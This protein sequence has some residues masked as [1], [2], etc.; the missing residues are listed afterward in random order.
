MN[1]ELKY[2]KIDA[3]ENPV[4]GTASSLIDD[5]FCFMMR[6]YKKCETCRYEWY[7]EEPANE[8]QVQL[9]NPR[10]PNVWTMERCLKETFN[11]EKNVECNCAS[12]TN[13]SGKTVTK[14]V[15]I[16]SRLV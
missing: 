7:T 2:P 3:E 13:C 14:T 15:K 1:R 6:E 16:V 10:R 4:A 9:G 11:K 8:L 12:G 5:Y